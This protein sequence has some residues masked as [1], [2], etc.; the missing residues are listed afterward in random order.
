MWGRGDCGQLGLG[1]R[2]SKQTPVLLAA[3]PEGTE[4]SQVR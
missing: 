1:G 4:V 2:E 3:F